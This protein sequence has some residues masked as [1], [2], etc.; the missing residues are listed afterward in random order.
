MGGRSAFDM[1]GNGDILFSS[2]QALGSNTASN[3][4][5]NGGALYLAGSTSGS[6]SNNT[7]NVV[8]EGNQAR[9]TA[10]GGIAYGGPSL[11]PRIWI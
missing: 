4:S 10:S 1:T 6:I 11:P 7:G 2:N 8:F 9:S 5:A 3:Q